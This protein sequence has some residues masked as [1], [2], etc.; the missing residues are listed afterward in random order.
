MVRLRA[1][2]SY[3]AGANVVAGDINAELIKSFETS[4]E[5]ER[6]LAVKCDVSD[7]QSVAA[8]FEQVKSRFSHVDIVVNNAGLLD[9]LDP[10]GTVSKDVWDRV[11]AVNLTGPMLVTQRAVQGFLEKKL[12]GSIVNV[13]S[14]AGTRG[15][16]AGK[17]QAVASRSHFL[18]ADTRLLP[19]CAYTAS[20]HGLVGLTKNTAAFYS[21]K[22]I[23]CNAIMPAGMS[24][25][26]AAGLANGYNEEGM[27]IVMAQNVSNVDVKKVA[28]M[29]LFLASDAAS[30]VNGSCL[31]ADKGWLAF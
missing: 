16:S 7:P 23:R 17:W 22:N 21:D 19:G 15:F 31:A 10:V 14:I 13:A 27:K 4:H 30:E 25:N 29:V 28:E 12:P 6:A 26:I 24:T 1:Y 8:L 20:K 11:I 5:A 18:D 2:R 9:R 3:A